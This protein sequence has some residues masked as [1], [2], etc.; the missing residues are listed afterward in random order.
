MTI[1]LIT[2][3]LIIFTGSSCDKIDK[4][5]QFQMAYNA[6]V[7]IPSS[8]GI[9]LPFNLFTPE[10]ESNAES[11]F[12]VNNTRKDLIQEIKL[13]KLDLSITSPSNGNFK[14]LKS[15]TIF[16]SAEG[17]SEIEIANKNDIPDNVGAFL[18][19]DTKD[20]DLKEYIKKDQFKLRLN[21][22]TDEIIASDHHIDVHSSYFVN[23]KILGI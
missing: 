16:I 3:S 6:S 19:L 4:L 7:V 23:A 13:T 5:T 12:S 22:I 14:F 2:L 17:L 1:R 21:T 11:T 18:S 8:T 15:I 20:V 9:N 10:I